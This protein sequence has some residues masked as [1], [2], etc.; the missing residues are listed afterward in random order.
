MRTSRKT[1]KRIA[2]QKALV[3][4]MTQEKGLV[5]C[6]MGAAANAGSAYVHL[7]GTCRPAT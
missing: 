3:E 5:D 7:V 2:Q 4:V 1:Q 6:R